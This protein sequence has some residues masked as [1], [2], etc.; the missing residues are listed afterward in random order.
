MC[1]NSTGFADNYVGKTELMC[2]I[3]FRQ[4]KRG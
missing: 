4:N 1:N 3:K 2:Y